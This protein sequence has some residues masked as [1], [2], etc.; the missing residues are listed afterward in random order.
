[1]TGG[2]SE[3]FV[4]KIRGL[5][6]FTKQYKETS[7]A[8]QRKFK[9]KR[10]YGRLAAERTRLE[11]ELR[12]TAEAWSMAVSSSGNGTEPSMD[13]IATLVLQDGEHCASE[14]ARVATTFQE[15]NRQMLAMLAHLK[16]EQQRGGSGDG[17]S[18]SRAVAAAAAASATARYEAL[19][20]LEP[21]EPLAAP[22]PQRAARHEAAAAVAA[23]R[24]RDA[25]TKLERMLTEASAAQDILMTSAIEEVDVASADAARARERVRADVLAH[26]SASVDGLD[27]V[28]EALDGVGAAECHDP[29]LRQNV[30]MSIAAA[31]GEHA[32]RVAAASEQLEAD[33]AAID[34]EAPRDGAPWT[35]DAKQRFATLCKEHG[36]E[37]AR[38]N[39]GVL[40][41][42][43]LDKLRLEFPARDAAEL[44]LQLRRARAA[45]A[46]RAPRCAR[47]GSARS[48]SDWRTRV[49]S[50]SA[51]RRRRRRCTPRRAR[52]AQRSARRAR[53]T[54]PSLRS[55]PRA[56]R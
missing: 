45:R 21:L 37:A 11:Q 14:L 13:R 28:V 49:F 53:A 33:L 12:G 34:L 48:P 51:P 38:S 2:S 10:E 19:E 56:P 47:S 16:Q 15:H 35:Y 36:I 50:S 9:W 22:S 6:Q 25:S 5:N 42:E 27:T 3:H 7:N 44:R 52:D 41:A 4:S 54:A 8:G 1:M 23:W 46:A 40:E 18:T 29:L 55:T 17:P 30:V 32:A 43:L 24:D 26:A 20:P 39:R 31:H